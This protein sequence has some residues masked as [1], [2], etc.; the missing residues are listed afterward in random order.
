MKQDDRMP[1]RVTAAILAVILVP[2]VAFAALAFTDAGAVEMRALDL[3]VTLIAIAV[4][5][6]VVL[7][8]L[9]LR[10]HLGSGDARSLAIGIALLGFASIYIWHG[11][12]TNSTPPFQFLVYGPASRV[13]FGA[14]LIGLSS[15]RRFEP[16]QRMRN[17]ILAAVGTVLVCGIGYLAAGT[18]GAAASS[19]SPSSLNVIRLGIE[20]LAIG[21]VTF[22]CIRFWRMIRTGVRHGAPMGRANPILLV[23]LLLTL[24]QSIFFMPSVPWGLT[25]WVAHAFGATGNLVLAWGTLVVLQEEQHVSAIDRLRE[26]DEERSRFIN[27]AAHELKTPLTPIRIQLHLLNSESGA[28]PEVRD[29]ALATITRNVARLSAIV[30]D[31]LLAARHDRGTPEAP[32]DQSTDLASVIETTIQSA[33]EPA[34]DAGVEFDRRVD[35]SLRVAVTMED[36]TQVVWGMLSHAIAASPRKGRVL[37]QA[38]AE[39]NTVILRVTDHGPPLTPEQRMHAFDPFPDSDLREGQPTGLALYVVRRIVESY[40]GRAWCDEGSDARG[41]GSTFAVSLPRAA[42]K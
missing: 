15:T 32:G 38:T 41:E 16:T 4:A 18:I 22:A 26:A 37:V 35:R 29:R 10:A 31:V 42:P 12:F 13:V 25:W 6:G 3:H 21:V 2:A 5:L 11:V 23:G 7:G 9:A 40:N 36:A 1:P 14:A 8:V 33:I 17:V 20:G 28:R 34:R 30:D 27:R 19:A 39:R 24:Q